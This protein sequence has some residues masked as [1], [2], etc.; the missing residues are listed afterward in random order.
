[1]VT[2]SN[3]FSVSALMRY[4]R[5]ASAPPS[6]GALADQPSLEAPSKAVTGVGDAF[7]AHTHRDD[8]EANTKQEDRPGDKKATADVATAGSE[9]SNEVAPGQAQ[10]VFNDQIE[11]TVSYDYELRRTFT[12][13]TLSSDGNVTLRIPSENFAKR[14]NDAVETMTIRA[15]EDAHRPDKG[16][17]LDV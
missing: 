17:D 12:D 15:W 6:A 9:A 7:L 5:T 16:I 1:M 14:L 2:V 3:D 10:D 8:A 11:K 4:D 13:I